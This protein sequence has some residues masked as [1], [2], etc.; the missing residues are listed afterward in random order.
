LNPHKTASKLAIRLKDGSEIEC[1]PKFEGSQSGMLFNPEL[2]M[3]KSVD[4][5][6]TIINRALMSAPL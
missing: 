4:R 5:W 1:T 3:S 6:V 2:A